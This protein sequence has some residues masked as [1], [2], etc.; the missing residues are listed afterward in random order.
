MRGYNKH[1]N[2]TSCSQCDAVLPTGAI[3]CSQCGAKVENTA[4]ISVGRQIVIYCVSFFL[5]PFGLGYVFKYLRRESKEEKRVGY[6]ALSL[7]ILAIL[8]ELW[9]GKMFIDAQTK[10]Y[11]ELEF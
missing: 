8:L 2:E 5:A 4:V 6:I 10:I 7:T 11:R 3:F 1:M 9:V